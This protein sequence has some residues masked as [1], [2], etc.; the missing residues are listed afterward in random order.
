MAKVVEQELS[1]NVRSLNTYIKD[2]TYF[3]QKLNNISQPQPN[4]TIMFCLDAKAL[5]LSVPRIEAKSACKTALENRTS[6]TISTDS[7][8]EMMD[9][10]LENNNLRFDNKQSL[11]TDGTAIGSHLGRNYACTYLGNWEQELYSKSKYLPSHYWRYVDDIWGLWYHGLEKLQQFHKLANS[12]HP[13]IQT[14]LR[15]SEKEIEFL[16]VNVSISEGYFKTDLYCKDTDKHMY[17]HASSSHPKTVKH[18]IQYG[19]G[20][21][22]KRICSEETDYNNRREDIKD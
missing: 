7:V 12:L 10:V 1:E 3:L 18:A 9:L 11:Q 22:V 15:Y 13:R 5:Y 8:L 21:R 4:E 20:I 19:L 6:K 14:E 2:T 16:D 17:L